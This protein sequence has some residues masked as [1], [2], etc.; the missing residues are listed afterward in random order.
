M[1]AVWLSRTLRQSLT[2]MEKW[3]GRWTHHGLKFEVLLS[4]LRKGSEGRDV[5]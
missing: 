4:V 5:L 3:V 1:P 2:D